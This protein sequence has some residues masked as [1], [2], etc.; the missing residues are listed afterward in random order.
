M[1]SLDQVGEDDGG[2]QRNPDRIEEFKALR[3]EILTTIE[4]QQKV[5]L[6]GTPILTVLL[7]LGFT[8]FDNDL[9]LASVGIFGTA[10][11]LGVA[12]VS[13]WMAEETRMI[14]ASFYIWTKLKFIWEDFVHGDWKAVE[15]KWKAE[16]RDEDFPKTAFRQHYKLLKSAAIFTLMAMFV[17]AFLLFTAS[18]VFYLYITFWPTFAFFILIQGLA[19]LDFLYLFY[20]LYEP[21]RFRILWKIIEE[22]RTLGKTES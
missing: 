12:L 10:S 7:G 13:L 22:E 17:I 19:V 1:I 8:L 5:L 6:S 14:R 15:K 16:G 2:P 4:G 20:L 3:A 21:G 11:V 9:F 18:A